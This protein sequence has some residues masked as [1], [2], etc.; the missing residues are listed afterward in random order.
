MEVKRTGGAAQKV[1]IVDPNTNRVLQGPAIKIVCLGIDGTVTQLPSLIVGDYNDGNYVLLNNNGIRLYGA[2]IPWDDLE[3]ALIG[4]NLYS[5]AGRIDANYAQGTMDFQDNCIYP[6]D[7]V[8][9]SYQMRHRYQWESDMEPHLHYFQT[10]AAFPNWCIQTRV[11]LNGGLVGAFSAPVKATQSVFTWSAGTLF[12]Y[13]DFPEIA[14]QQNLSF[15]L[16]V[17][18]YRD[19]TNVTGL[20]SGADPVAG[21]VSSKFLDIHFK[22]DMLGSFLELQK[23]S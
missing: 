20:F 15:A 16:D 22:N 18:L 21:N 6:D 9:I 13:L 23:Y 8:I 10:V 5:P 12:Q 4:A 2:A 14:G 7:F 11:I 1:V 3:G 19:T 17:K